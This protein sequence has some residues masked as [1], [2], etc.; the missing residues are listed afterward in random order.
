MPVIININPESTEGNRGKTPGVILRACVFKDNQHS[1]V[2]TITFIFINKIVKLSP[3]GIKLGPGWLSPTRNP[4]PQFIEYGLAA[5]V[6]NNAEYK[7]LIDDAFL[8]IPTISIATD[9]SNLF[10]L[11]TGIYMNAMQ[12]GIQWERPAS[13]ELIYPDG[14]KVLKLMQELESEED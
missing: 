1:E 10:D 13:I 2:A 8:S 7:D 4:N 3:E 9:L 12:D 11:K 14:K 6:I 5:D